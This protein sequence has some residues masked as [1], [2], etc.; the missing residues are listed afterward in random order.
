MKVRHVS[1]FITTLLFAFKLNGNR[2]D[3]YRNFLDCHSK[4]KMYMYLTVT[5]ECDNL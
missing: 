4:R 1:G 5:L 2:Q 3:I